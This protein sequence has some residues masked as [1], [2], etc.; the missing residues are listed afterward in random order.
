MF[1]SLE[2]SIKHE[3][4]DIS[5]TWLEKVVEMEQIMAT[6]RSVVS[7]T[8]TTCNMPAPHGDG[9]RENLYKALILLTDIINSGFQDGD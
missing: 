4:G 8:S 1:G 7:S 3:A 9:L 5:A 2:I 6:S